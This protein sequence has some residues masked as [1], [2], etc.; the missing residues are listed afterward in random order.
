MFHGV[1]KKENGKLVYSDHAE[2]L[3]YDL[4]LKNLPEG[5]TIE[6]YVE[7]VKSDGSVAQLAKV[8][9][10]IRELANFLG[11][12]F[13]EMKYEIKEKAGLCL[14]KDINGSQV[15]VC[16][17]FAACSKMELGMAINAC[18]EIGDIVGFNLH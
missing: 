15:K 10:M 3:K 16:K 11:Y 1:L 2:K 6:I 18:L 9:A 8:H 5:A 14:V 13:E 4:F 12:T 7:A 17:S